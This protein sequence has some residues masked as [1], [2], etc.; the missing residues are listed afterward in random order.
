MPP[1]PVSV[2]AISRH[3]V[4]AELARVAFN[5]FCATGFNQVTFADLA[6]ATG[7]SRSTFLR[8]FTNKEDVVLFLFD[9]IG[10]T[11]I[12]ALASD[13]RSDDDWHALRRALNP[14]VDF[15]MR[16]TSEV[17]A[18]LDLIYETPAL[19]ARFREKQFDWRPNIVRQLQRTHAAPDAS[20]VTQVRVAAA[21]ECFAAALAVWRESEGREDLSTLIDTSFSALDPTI[22]IQTS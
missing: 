11:I 18:F 16:D 6:G 1:S 3:A 15:L 22:A 5:E 7:V 19:S 4:R 17:M 10:D 8:Y 9:P 12:E 14:V 13:A 2:R 21:M 20:I